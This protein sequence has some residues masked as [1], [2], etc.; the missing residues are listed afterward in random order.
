[1]KAIKLSLSLLLISFLF[2]CAFYAPHDWQGSYKGH[3]YQGSY[4]TSVSPCPVP[5]LMN[6]GYGYQ[7]RQ[8]QT[9]LSAEE[10]KAVIDNYIHSF[11]NPNIKAGNMK[12]TGAA[13]EF[14]IVTKENSLV[15]KV[16]V[17]KYTGLFR[18]AYK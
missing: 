16:F 6:P 11:N 8:R 13:F 15:D 18:S 4:A 7:D 9:P 3:P 1:M 10:A 2:G 17:D 14:E 12:D 5:W